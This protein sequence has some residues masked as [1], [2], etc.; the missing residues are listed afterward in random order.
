MFVAA[1]AGIQERIGYAIPARHRLLTY[2]VPPPQAKTHRLS[3]QKG[4]TIVEVAYGDKV[5]E[6]DVVRLEDDY[7]RS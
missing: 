5:V 1:L 6:D 2:A 3:S 7:G 4:G